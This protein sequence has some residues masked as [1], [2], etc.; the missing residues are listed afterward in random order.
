MK[1]KLYI[2]SSGRANRNG[3]ILE[4]THTH[5]NR[6]AAAAD[7]YVLVT[8]TKALIRLSVGGHARHTLER[9]RIYTKC[10]WWGALVESICAAVR[11]FLFDM[12]S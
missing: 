2:G 4:R 11:R 8:A 9:I 10:V 3:V 1:L 6:T 12:L 7:V 5:T